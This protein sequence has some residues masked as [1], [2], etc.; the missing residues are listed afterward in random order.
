MSKIEELESEFNELML[1]WEY[2]EDS[3]FYIYEEEVKNVK[4]LIQEIK[5]ERKNNKN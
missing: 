4:K 3:K 5:D 2:Q 1:T